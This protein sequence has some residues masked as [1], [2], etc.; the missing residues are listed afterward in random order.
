M[1]ELKRRQQKGALRLYLRPGRG[2]HKLDSVR[3]AT[4][5][6]RHTW[7]NTPTLISYPHRD[8]TPCPRPGKSIITTKLLKTSTENTKTSVTLTQVLEA[9]KGRYST[10]QTR[11]IT[12]LAEDP[13]VPQAT[14]TF[15]PPCSVIARRM[16]MIWRRFILGAIGAANDAP[17]AAR[18][19][20]AG[21][22]CV[23]VSACVCW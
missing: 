8:I 3:T 20:C 1:K 23:L 18:E 13:V 15:T 5:R 22:H 7:K 4:S 19:A 14:A 17:W 2:G 12:K 6:R 21:L 16:T 9:G 10:R 11:V